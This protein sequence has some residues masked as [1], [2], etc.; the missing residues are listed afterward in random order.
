MQKV[1]V[2]SFGYRTSEAE[3]ILEAF[4]R[5]GLQGNCVFDVNALIVS[6]TSPD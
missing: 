4:A 6:K 2:L 3:H 5:V 1:A